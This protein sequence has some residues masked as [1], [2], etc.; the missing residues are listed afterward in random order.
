[1]DSFKLVPFRAVLRAILVG[2]VAALCAVRVNDILVTVPDLS[3]GTFSRY[4]APLIEEVLKAA[5]VVYLVDRRRVGFLVDAAIYGFAVGAGFALVENVDYLLS[6]PRAGVFLWIVRGF[7][8]ALLHGGTTAT[9][10]VLSMGLADRHPDRR[11]GVFVPGVFAAV[12]LHSLY[13]HFVLP[14]VAATAALLVVL[15]LVLFVVFE[16][17]EAATREWLGFGF[18]TDIEVLRLVTSSGGSQTRVGSYLRSLRARVPGLVVA[19]M[20]CLLRLQL[21]LSIRAKGL[22]MAREAGVEMPVGKDVRAAF[23]EMRYLERSIGPTG[24]L[25]LKPILGRGSRDLWELYMLEQA[26]S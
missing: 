8:T 13:N 2:G 24:L 3:P 4:V 9:L 17:S 15:P 21:E 6:L 25:A 1:M 5:Y 12:A 10:A 19:D 18:D 26:S 22:L 23:Q 16:R 14:P 7:G 20:L 11:F